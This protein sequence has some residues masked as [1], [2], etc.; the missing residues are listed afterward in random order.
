MK[1]LFSFVV[2]AVVAAAAV[3]LVWLQVPLAQVGALLA[4]AACL[5]WLG[6]VVVLPWNLFFRARQTAREL[7]RARER[8]GVVTDEQ[9]A[10]AR[11]VERLMLRVSVG[12]HVVSAAALALGA[13]WAR[14]PLGQLFAVLF[15]VSTWF[16][17][18]VEYYR[19]LRGLLSELVEDA[20]Y[21]WADVVQ[22]TAEVAAQRG[23][24]EAAEKERKALD[25][26]LERSQA[27]LEGR[28]AEANRR[29]ELVARRFDESIE[30]LTDNRELISG[31]RAF[32]KMVREG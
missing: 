23:L 25:E 14:Q 4:G 21:P 32:L 17:P 10:R 29:L 9:V 1:S 13:W 8:G 19:Y 12:L 20:R 28:V 5:A 30:R 22:L 2:G 7:L 24:L 3:G 18:A 27:M 15:L 16:R 26:R 31:L 11:Q 6:V